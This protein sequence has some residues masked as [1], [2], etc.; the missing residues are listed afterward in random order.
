MNKLY[1]PVSQK[2]S[3]Y[4]SK[5]YFGASFSLILMKQK[6]NGRGMFLNQKYAA[7]FLYISEPSFYINIFLAKK[8]KKKKEKHEKIHK[9]K[10][11]AKLK[12]LKV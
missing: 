6:L 1:R 11:K 3:Y 2:I 8:V 9:T 4:P 7:F 5:I 12:N 10:T